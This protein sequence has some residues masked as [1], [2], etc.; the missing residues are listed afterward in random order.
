MGSGHAGALPEDQSLS[1]RQP[2]QPQH[3][4]ILC[5][6]LCSEAS[7]FGGSQGVPPESPGL[8][9]ISPRDPEEK[10]AEPGAGGRPQPA[11]KGKPE[12][13]GSCPCAQGRAS[14]GTHPVQG[15]VGDGHRY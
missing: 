7:E 9:R 2:L 10:R 11:G 12:K 3:R 6:G 5:E 4:T 8:V 14:P 13:G 1:P 15:G